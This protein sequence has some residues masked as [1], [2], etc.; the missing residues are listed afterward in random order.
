VVVQ[1]VLVLVRLQHRGVQPA[2][3]DH[4]GSV[5]KQP[6]EQGAVRE[7]QL[8]DGRLCE[9]AAAIFPA[10][11]PFAVPPAMVGDRGPHLGQARRLRRI[12][13]VVW[14]KP[15]Q[16][17]AGEVQKTRGG[18][19]HDA[20][21]PLPLLD[22]QERVGRMLQE[23]VVWRAHEKFSMRACALDVMTSRHGRR[24]QSGLP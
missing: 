22:H 14:T 24:P 11:A 15:E 5:P 9:H 16:F 2:A 17:V 23:R 3:A 13:D 20:V 6:L 10:Q 19:V 1:L 4:V 12:I 7:Y 18:G 8:D 21:A